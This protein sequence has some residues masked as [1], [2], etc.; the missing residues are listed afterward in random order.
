[1]PEIRKILGQSNPA[2]L[3]LTDLYTVPASTQAVVSTVTVCNADATPVQFRIS[4]AQGGAA[5]AQEQYLY[6]DF[7]IPEG[8]AFAS[9][10]GITLDAGDVI[11]CRSTGSSTS[12]QVF[13]VEITP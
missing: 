4:V 10:I 5:N 9:T 2:A 7:S 6:W 8:D 1:M 11:R 13:G 3:T 12:F